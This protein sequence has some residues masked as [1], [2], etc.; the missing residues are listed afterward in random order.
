MDSFPKLIV[1]FLANGESCEGI[2]A[3]VFYTY[4]FLSVHTN[5]YW[6]YC[7]FNCNVPVDFLCAATATR[8][9]TLAIRIP[10]P[11]GKILPKS[12]GLAKVLSKCC[13]SV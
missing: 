12:Q 13:Q 2:V 7:W 10:F 1:S 3:H 11:S 9:H 8:K 4:E 6:R 5:C